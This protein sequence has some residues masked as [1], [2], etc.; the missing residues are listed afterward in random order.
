ML[1]RVMGVLMFAAVGLAPV[2]F[3][4][5]GALVDLNPKIMFTAAGAIV[6]L[7]AGLSAANRTV[8]TI[9]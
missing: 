5:S 4:V 3:V 6:L 7:V 9:D 1:G 8:R 2:S